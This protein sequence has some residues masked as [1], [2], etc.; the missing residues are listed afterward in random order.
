MIFFIYGADTFRS[1]QR[2]NF[3]KEGFKKKYDSQGLNIEIIDG[4]KFSLEDF[5]SKLGNQSLLSQK[6]LLIIEKLIEK[7]KKS[8][9]QKRLIEYLKANPL[10]E[11]EILIFWEGDLADKFSGKRVKEK[12]TSKLFSYLKQYARSEEFNLLKGYSLKNWVK[13]EINKRKGSIDDE[14]LNLLLALVG[15]DLWQM[16]NEIEKL[17]NYKKGK[18]ISKKD[19]EMFVKAKY[20]TDIFRLTDAIAER[21]IKQALKLIHEQIISGANELYL[22]AMLSRLFRILLQV[23][24]IG[25]EESNTYTIASRLGIHP[26]VAQKAFQQVKNF[27]LAELKKIYEYLL[28]I[29]LKI[30]T[31]QADPKLLFD[32]FIVDVCRL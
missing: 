12:E 3:Y 21:K 27:S 14:A 31:S 19:V 25:R 22:L 8:G 4:E 24:E 5:R 16:N 15:S 11:N 10:S 23:K 9:V 1:R 18:I 13:K 17:V 7:G 20:D 32:L 30:K 28:S 6:R 29:D 2:L 26:F